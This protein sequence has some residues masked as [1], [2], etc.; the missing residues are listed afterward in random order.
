MRSAIGSLPLAATGCGTREP[1]G[2]F[3]AGISADLAG[4]VT[5]GFGRR[6]AA[7]GV[8]VGLAKNGVGGR[9]DCKKT[10][11]AM[12]TRLAA[13][14]PRKANV[15][16]GRCSAFAHSRNPMYVAFM[17]V[18]IGEFL[19]FPNWILLIYLAGFLALVHRQVLREEDF[20]QAHYGR[21]YL[22]YCSRVRRYF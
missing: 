5:A 3:A 12:M 22:D 1:T 13:A 17:L 19:I 9:L 2:E 7:W 14:A 11:L 6:S 16:T 8:E 21:Q 20:L 4:A 18:L 15:S 10:A